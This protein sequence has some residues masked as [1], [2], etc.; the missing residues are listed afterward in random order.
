MTPE[1]LA[2]RLAEY[3]AAGWLVFAVPPGIGE[4]IVDGP[5][6]QQTA[7]MLAARLKGLEALARQADPK[8]PVREEFIVCHAAG[9]P[10]PHRPHP[11]TLG[12]ALAFA[13]EHRISGV[14]GAPVDPQP[15]VKRRL[16]SDWKDVER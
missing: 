10:D 4:D 11:N 12:E 5:A 3:G 1:E 13:A 9:Y 2:D 14:T 16:V 15:V 7:L 8:M 6:T